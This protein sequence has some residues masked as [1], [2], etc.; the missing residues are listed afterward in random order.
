MQLSINWHLCIGS[1]LCVATAPAA[2]RLVPYG[3]EY[4][5]AL[6]D[7]VVDYD[8]ILEAAR[9]CPTLAIRLTENG[10]PLYPPPPAG[11]PR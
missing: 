1:G 2:F 6:I 10:A 3:N 7:P 4:R 9:A 8:L 11:S 5:A